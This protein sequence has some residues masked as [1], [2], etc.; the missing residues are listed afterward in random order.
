[1]ASNEKSADIVHSNDGPFDDRDLTEA[2]RQAGETEFWFKIFPNAGFEPAAIG[3]E[4]PWEQRKRDLLFTNADVD[5]LFN[6]LDLLKE[7]FE[8]EAMDE[9]LDQG[10]RG[11]L[12]CIGDLHQYGRVTAPGLAIGAIKTLMRNCSL[13][14]RYFVKDPPTGEDE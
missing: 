14:D 12:S 5:D 3:R 7:V 13:F 1:M 8:I 11:A 6:D 4:I 9:D 10:L 2:Q